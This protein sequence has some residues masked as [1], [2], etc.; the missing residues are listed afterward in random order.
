VWDYLR[1]HP[2]VAAFD[3][4]ADTEGGSGVTVVRLRE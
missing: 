2:S 4:P 1:E 3:H